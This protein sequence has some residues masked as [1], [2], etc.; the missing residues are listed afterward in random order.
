LTIDRFLHSPVEEEEEGVVVGGVFSSFV[1][2]GRGLTFRSSF[3]FCGGDAVAVEEVA[4]DQVDFEDDDNGTI[5]CSVDPCV[6]DTC[7]FLMMINGV[8]GRMRLYSIG[9]G[10][11]KMIKDR[12][13][14]QKSM[15]L[16][17]FR[18][19]TGTAKRQ[20]KQAGSRK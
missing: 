4:C 5:E 7:A 16:L 8:Q 3:S 15:L 6:W 12:T 11:G 10:K 2:T 17:S 9:G 19:S 20:R 14:L 18:V 13:R 1:M